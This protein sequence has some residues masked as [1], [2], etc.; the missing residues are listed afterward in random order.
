MECGQL[1]V[2]V[3]NVG[4]YARV[5]KIDTISTDDFLYLFK[6]NVALTAFTFS[7]TALP[8]LRKS[9]RFH[10]QYR[11]PGWAGRPRRQC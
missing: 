6:L 2:V 4:T 7:K 11:Q 10:R 3:N 9:H 1:D 8:L 5:R